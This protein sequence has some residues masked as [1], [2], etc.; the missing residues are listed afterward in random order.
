VGT[1]AGSGSL[2]AA[3]GQRETIDAR[4]SLLIAVTCGE[5]L[6]RSVEVVPTGELDFVLLH[7]GEE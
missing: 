4:G 2:L 5:P 6:P 1:D 7:M 3:I